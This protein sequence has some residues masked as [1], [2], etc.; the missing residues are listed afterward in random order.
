MSQILV[1]IAVLVGPGLPVNIH[2]LGR[3]NALQAQADAPLIGIDPNYAQRPHIALLNDLTRV[4]DALVAQ[5]GQVDQ[6]LDVVI[7][8]ARKGAKLDQLG[9]RPFD[10]LLDVVAI[11]R[12]G[13]RI[14]FQALE[15][16]PDA[17]AVA[18]DVENKDLNFVAHRQDSRSGARRGATKARTGGSG[19]PRHPGPQR[20]QSRTG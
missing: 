20:R 12:S 6:A 15:A 11:L 10:Q 5:L 7:K 17:P 1:R 18:I 14:G 8:D 13:P 4:I 3:G 19:H 2:I 16:Q 9:D